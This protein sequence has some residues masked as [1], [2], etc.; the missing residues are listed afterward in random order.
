MREERWVTYGA[1]VVLVLILTLQLFPIAWMVNTSLMTQLEAATGSLLPKTPR[2]ENYLDIWRVLPFFHYLKN[3]LLV[4]SLTTLFALGIAT[5]AGYALARFRFPGAELFG[6]SVLLTQVI[7]GI[8]FLIPI[9]IMYIAF[10]NWVRQALGLEI[11]LV[12]TYP[13]LILTY[14][15]FFVPISIWILRGFFA[16]IPKELEEA[17]LVDGATPFQAFRQVILPLALPGIAATAV[18]IFL[19]A[20][21]ELLFA[22]I[23]TNEATATIPV[24][25]RNFVGNYQNRYD[26]VMAAATVATLPVLVLFFLVQRWL[27]QGLTAGAVKG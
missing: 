26:L 5:L 21:D 3:S 10:Q 25:I 4:C 9:Y 24:G 6:G 17:A 27:I 14:T 22:Q 19:T 8:L 1:W 15:A 23:L 12:G 7:P 18:Y 13:G 2:W 16:S 20:W 11:R